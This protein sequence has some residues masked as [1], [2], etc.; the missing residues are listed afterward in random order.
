[1]RKFGFLLG[2][3]WMAVQYATASKASCE[4]YPLSAHL[5][6]VSYYNY[7]NKKCNKRINNMTANLGKWGLFSINIIALFA[8]D[9]EQSDHRVENKMRICPEGESSGVAVTSDPVEISPEKQWNADRDL[10][11]SVPLDDEA[12]TDLR[13]VWAT[14]KWAD[15]NGLSEK[16]HESARRVLGKYL[17][18]GDPYERIALGWAVYKLTSSPPDSKVRIGG[19]TTSVEESATKGVAQHVIALGMFDF[20]DEFFER[21]EKCIYDHTNEHCRKELKWRLRK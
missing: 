21:T 2:S 19:G 6:K 1:M 20:A 11:F 4:K 5:I 16:Q 7:S 10:I 9:S 8:C 15:N 18:F 17:A 12:A 3:S 13:E 14:L